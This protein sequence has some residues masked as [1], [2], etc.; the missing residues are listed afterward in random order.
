[1]FHISS[2]AF[3][4]ELVFSSLPAL[5]TV[6]RLSVGW[7]SREPRREG[8]GEGWQKQPWSAFLKHPKENHTPP[9]SIHS[10]Y[11]LARE[12]AANIKITFCL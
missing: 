8:G 6:P 12:R 7:G 1:M 10:F 9:F 2:L 11:P 3:S 4:S 5:S